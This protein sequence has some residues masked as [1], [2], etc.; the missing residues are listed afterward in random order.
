MA[1]FNPAIDYYAI[2]GVWSSPVLVDRS[3]ML[4]SQRCCKAFHT[5]PG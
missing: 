3:V 5:Q 4:L 1:D 2:L